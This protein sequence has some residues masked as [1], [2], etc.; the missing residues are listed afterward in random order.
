MGDLIVEIA[1]SSRETLNA[2]CPMEKKKKSLKSRNKVL[3]IDL[4][5][6]AE[7]DP[8]SKAPCLMSV[9]LDIR[10]KA[11]VHRDLTPSPP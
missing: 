4:L 1:S 10:S 5:V 11:M 8:C 6:Y 3:P 9:L 7:I 2:E